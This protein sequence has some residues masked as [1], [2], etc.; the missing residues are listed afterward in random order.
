MYLYMSIIALF[1]MRPC[2]QSHFLLAC[3]YGQ[4]QRSWC[5]DAGLSCVH[6]S[7]HSLWTRELTES[8]KWL[9]SSYGTP[10]AVSMCESVWRLWP[11]RTNLV[12]L[13]YRLTESSLLAGNTS[14]LS[15]TSGKTF[16]DKSLTG[17]RYGSVNICALLCFFP[18]RYRAG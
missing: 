16:E 1:A 12:F 3:Q 9:L 10:S 11:G 2:P 18:P 5:D 8:F 6:L 17:P 15:N 7:N 13:E 4:L 14:L